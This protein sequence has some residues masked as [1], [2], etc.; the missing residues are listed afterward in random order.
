ME[1]QPFY[2]SKTFWVMVLGLVA[3]I[4]NEQFGFQIPETIIAAVMA[5]LGILFRWVADQPLSVKK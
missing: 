4:A 1:K 5:V 2:T 3:F